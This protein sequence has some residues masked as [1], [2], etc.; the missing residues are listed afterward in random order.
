V[1]RESI[2]T[3]QWITAEPRLSTVPLPFN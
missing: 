2:R 1:V 3:R